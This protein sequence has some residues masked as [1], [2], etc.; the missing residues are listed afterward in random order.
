MPQEHVSTLLSIGLLSPDLVTIIVIVDHDDCRFRRVQCVRDGCVSNTPLLAFLKFLVRAIGPLE[1]PLNYRLS[2]NVERRKVVDAILDRD[3]NTALED[4]D[5]SGIESMVVIKDV[6]RN[7]RVENQA[8]RDFFLGGK[9]CVGSRLEIP[10]KFSHL[11]ELSDDLILAGANELELFHLGADSRRRACTMRTFK[12]R[13]SGDVASSKYAILE[14]SRHLSYVQSSE[15]ERSKSL[16]EVLSLVQQLDAT[17][18]AIC[19]GFAMGDSTKAIA[20]SVGLTSRSVEKRRQ[21]I[22]DRFGF[23]RPIEIVK[24]LVRLE[25]NGLFRISK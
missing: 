21:K 18:Q 5:L 24:M 19:R 6:E 1:E 12:R 15:E 11:S 25:V 23:E 13:L 3:A 14:V 10:P 16:P 4:M 17:D 9:S 8:F 20:L 2:F 22:M 7:V